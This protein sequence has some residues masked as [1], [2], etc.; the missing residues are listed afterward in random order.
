MIA[1]GADELIIAD[2]G[3]LGPLDVQLGKQDELF[4]YSSGLDINQALLSLNMRARAAFREALIEIRTGS[5]GSISTK[6]ASEIATNL[7]ASLYGRIYEQ[8]DPV[9]LGENERAIQIAMH[10]GERL[11]GGN[12]KNGTLDTLVMR[13]SSHN[14]VIDRKEAATLF[15]VVRPLQKEE[16]ELVGALN[17]SLFHNPND[18]MRPLIQKLKSCQE[19][20]HETTAQDHV[21]GSAGDQGP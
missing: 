12:V 1:I 20:A 16:E 8:I 3:E 13:Y 15:R 14:F 6:M 10:Y 18:D 4:E 19:S 5:G 21:N 2:D 11:K 7:A 17:E 9:K